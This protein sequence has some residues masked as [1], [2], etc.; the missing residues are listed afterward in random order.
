MQEPDGY[1]FVVT[2][3]SLL[4]LNPI[5]NPKAGYDP[6]N[7]LTNVAYLAGSPVAFLVS[8]ASPVKSLG[9]LV[10][11]GRTGGRPLTYS[12]SGVGSNGH[13]LAEYFGRKAG[14]PV[15]LVPYKGAAQG[16]TDLIG[17]HLDFSAQTLSSGSGLAPTGLHWPGPPDCRATSPRRSIA[18][19]R[20]WCSGR[21]SRNACAKTG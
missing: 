21:T 1:N 4:A 14:I 12:S 2:T 19:S 10:A 17:G 11:R 8:A 18:R 16:L 13:L 15:A 6:L 7:D 3:L 9:D 20:R 5:A